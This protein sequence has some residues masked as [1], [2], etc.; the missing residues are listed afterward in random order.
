MSFALLFRR[1]GKDQGGYLTAEARQ[2]AAALGLV[3]IAAGGA[4]IG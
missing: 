3:Y 1:H 4:T 2:R